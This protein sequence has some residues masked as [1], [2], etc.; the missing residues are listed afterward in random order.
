MRQDIWPGGRAR[1]YTQVRRMRDVVL[2]GRMLCVDPA[3]GS[4][5]QVGWALYE[6]GE[7]VKSGVLAVAKRGAIGVRLADTRKQLDALALGVI[8][9]LVVELLRGN[10]VHAYLHWAT[11]TIVSAIPHKVVIE[12]P[13]QCWKA[14]IAGDPNYFK[15]DVEDAKAFGITLLKLAR[16]LRPVDSLGDVA[17]GQR[18]EREPADR[19]VRIRAAPSMG[20][21]RMVG[22]KRK[23]SKT[24][25]RRRGKA[26][27]KRRSDRR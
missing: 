13:I 19:P 24:N 4:T 20:T 2:T 8:D 7:L 1:F 27:T 15:D 26:T 10:R 6:A 16:G 22:P 21:S 9:L 3:S 11:G 12:L 14:A 25:N 18:L 5:S 17:G 23:R